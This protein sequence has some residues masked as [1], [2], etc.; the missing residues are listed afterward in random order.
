MFIGGC[1]EKTKTTQSELDKSR[2]SVTEAYYRLCEIYSGTDVEKI[3]EFYSDDIVR[4]PPSG[5]I[6]TGKA[7]LREDKTKTRQLNIYT[8]DE[9]SPPVVYPSVDQTV[10]YSTFKDTSISIETGDTTKTKGTWVAV[11][12]KQSDNVWKINLS[13]FTNN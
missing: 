3:L 8:L 5:E 4:I 7:L 13:T 9:Y 11:W 2:A 6:L 10:T 1:Y 12:E